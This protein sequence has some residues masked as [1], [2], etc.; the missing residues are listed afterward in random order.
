MYSYSTVALTAATLATFIQ[1]CP[2]PPAVIGGLISLAPKLISGALSAAG[3]GAVAGAVSGAV[4]QADQKRDDSQVP[5]GIT[6]CF[7]QAMDNNPTAEPGAG[8]SII[9]NNL[10]KSCIAEVQAYNAHPANGAMAAVHG[11]TTQINRTAVKLDGIPDGLFGQIK[12]LI[13]AQPQAQAQRRAMRF[14]KY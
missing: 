14:E 1:P 4:G 10:P 13:K 3:S 6:H 2:A 8:T 12:D 11:T 7:A 5:S 9:V